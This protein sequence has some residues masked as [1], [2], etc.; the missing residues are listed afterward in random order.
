MKWIAMCLSKECR[1]NGA[2]CKVIDQ[3]PNGS[4][5]EAVAK[6]HKNEN[7]D[8]VVIVGYEINQ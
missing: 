6:R 8:H 7:P 3:A 1:E 2:A 5:I 4:W